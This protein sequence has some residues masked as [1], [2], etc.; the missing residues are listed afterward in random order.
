MRSSLSKTHFACPRADQTYPTRGCT[1]PS[2]QPR[3][4]IHVYGVPSTSLAR[5]GF[6]PRHRG[7]V[8]RSN[9]AE[10]RAA[11]SLRC[12]L[13][14]WWRQLGAR[15]PRHRHAPWDRGCPAHARTACQGRRSAS[16]V[17]RRHP[18]Q[19]RPIGA[20]IVSTPQDVAL[21]DVRKGVAMLRKVSVPVI[22]PLCLP[23]YLYFHLTPEFSQMTGIILNESHF[24]CPSCTQPH[25]LFGSPDG[26][27]ATAE[28]IGIEILAELP[29]VPGVSS[30]G[31]AGVPYSL[32]SSD[33]RQADGLGGLEWNE[34][35]IEVA[36]K[37]WEAI[38][39]DDRL[40][41]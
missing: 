23:S 26:F 10:G 16:I 21:S 13:V 12:Q 31:D 27:R 9:G 18:A 3:P 14:R 15:R 41:S 36:A 39:T 7:R 32:V 11:A 17:S 22:K 34:K 4:S 40:D 37:T 28:R 2:R 24:I 30:A 25:H 33:R 38:S 29:L 35:M 6:Y 1:L 8:A 5:L 20:V 19:S